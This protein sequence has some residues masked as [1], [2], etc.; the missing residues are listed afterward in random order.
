V[1][2]KVIGGHK[3]AIALQALANKITNGGS[4]K[5]GF[6]EGATYPAGDNS[7]FL[8]AV[9]SS[10]APTPTKSLPVAQVAFWNE[11]GTKRAKARPFF[12]NT[13]SD[14]AENWGAGLAKLVVSTNFDGQKSLT[15]LGVQ[16]VNDIKETINKW[17][18]DNRPLTVKIK[19]FNKGL[20]HNKIMRDAVAFKV[21]T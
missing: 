1:A 15:L 3:F 13:I 5:V 17:P 19:G 10:A 6:L 8:K 16:M 2:V 9:G 20:I 14:K 12:R 18:A 4:L 11:F 21:E 7:A